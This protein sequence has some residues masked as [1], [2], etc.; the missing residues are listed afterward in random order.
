M[1]SPGFE[2][3]RLTALTDFETA[4]DL[5]KTDPKINTNQEVISH[6][7]DQFDLETEEKFNTVS[8]LFNYIVKNFLV[9]NLPVSTD[10]KLKYYP[11][12]H[13]VPEALNLAAF[14]QDMD[15]VKSVK[16]NQRFYLDIVNA[17][18]KLGGQKLDL[19]FF[20]TLAKAVDFLDEK[21]LTDKINITD[22]DSNA[23][24][25]NLAKNWLWDKIYD[26]HS[27]LK[28]VDVEKFKVHVVN[29]LLASRRK[30]I[31]KNP[32]KELEKIDITPEEYIKIIKSDGLPFNLYTK[33]QV[34]FFADDIRKIGFSKVNLG[35][36]SNITNYA[37]LKAL[38]DVFGKKFTHP[39]RNEDTW[40]ESANVVPIFFFST[41][42]PI[43]KELKIAKYFGFTK[44]EYLTNRIKTLNTDSYRLLYYVKEYLKRGYPKKKIQ[45]ELNEYYRHFPDDK[46]KIE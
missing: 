17:F 28:P 30:G 43:R 41:E 4:I 35:I 34:E 25:F 38:S 21:G 11:K 18:L 29:G 2:V 22:L 12:Y 44:Q 27:K 36:R 10:F 19:K 16:F 15:F 14:N 26:E 31:L 20:G 13:T 9:Q 23:L 32:P 24:I 5:A 37:T 6:Y 33:R 39:L 3:R 45:F 1:N 46:F 8:S 7:I 40:K 42:L